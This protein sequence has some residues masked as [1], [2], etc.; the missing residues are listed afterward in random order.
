MWARWWGRASS[1]CKSHT[2]THKGT[3][4]RECMCMLTT[5]TVRSF[6]KF[7]GAP[8]NIT[9]RAT[10]SA[11]PFG[12][13][14]LKIQID[15]HVYTYIFIYTHTYLCV[16]VSAWIGRCGWVCLVLV[17]ARG[18]GG[19]ARAS[20]SFG[21]VPSPSWGGCPLHYT[22]GGGGFPFQG[23]RLCLG[24]NLP[25]PLVSSRPN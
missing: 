3:K 19:S 6:R 1:S 21:V 11:C 23:S 14:S 17:S 13:S 15:T 7:P 4:V 2:P 25:L 18:G 20:K 22:G 12:R 24:P 9:L 8:E 16:C 5:Y 10:S